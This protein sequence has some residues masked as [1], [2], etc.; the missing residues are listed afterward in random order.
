ME[1]L[2]LLIP[3]ALLFAGGFVWAY[4]R[5]VRAGQF[6]DLETPPIRALFDDEGDTSERR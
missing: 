6:D 3:L 5:A 4:I 2:A 1:A